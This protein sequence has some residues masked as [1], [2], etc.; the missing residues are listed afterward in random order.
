MS[1]IKLIVS[2]RFQK[3]MNKV[4]LLALEEKVS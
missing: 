1:L 3:C 4:K 2:L